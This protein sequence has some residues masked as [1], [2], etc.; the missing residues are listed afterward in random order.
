MASS[1]AANLI[2]AFDPLCGWCFGFRPT[3]RVLRQA[4]AGRVTFQLASAGLVTGERERPIREVAASLERGMTLVER[5]T[6]ARFGEDF[7]RKVLTRGDWVLR[8]EPGCRAMF[9]AEQLGGE[10]AID[11]AEAL[12]TAFYEEGA[13]PDEVG[14]LRACAEEAELDADAL[15]AAWQA[16]DAAPSTRAAFAL[17]RARGVSSY[18]AVFLDRGAQLERI[19]EGYVEPD[20]AIDRVEAVLT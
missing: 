13:L 14:T 18:P 6:G 1:V 7:R 11:F 4:L 8:S 16:P 5:R 17:W 10:R 19:F 2:L 20:V 9:V 3:L 15:V 12:V